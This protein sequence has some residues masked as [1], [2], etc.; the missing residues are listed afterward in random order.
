MNSVLVVGATGNVG[1]QVVDGLVAEGVSTRALARDPGAAVFPEGVEV[2]AGDLA[3]PESLAAAADGVESVFLVWP[4]H[5]TQGA[6]EVLKVLGEH[7][8]RVVYLSSTTVNDEGPQS[9]LIPQRHAEIEA[10]LAE[11]GM[12]WTVL[13]AD[14]IASNMLGWAGQIRA[15]DVVRGTE[16]APTAVVHEGDIAAVAVR[17][18]TDHSHTWRKYLVTGPRVV[19][20][21]DQVQA[22]AEVLGRPLRFEA[23]PLDVA[24]ESMTAAGLPAALIESLL[25]MA[26]FRPRSDLITTT[27]AD[28]TGRAARDIREWAADHAAVFR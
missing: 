15:G 26:A 12:P 16:V 10:L 23:L 7:A 14:T 11:S 20:R 27:V 22:I 25:S 8:Q 24:R 28:L 21:D 13:R 5:D 6:A 17:L 4:F 19:S 2:V 18:L 1:R 9:D 3:V